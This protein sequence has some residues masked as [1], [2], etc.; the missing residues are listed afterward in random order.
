MV[1]TRKT[2][3]YLVDTIEADI[4]SGNEPPRRAFAADKDC[5]SNPLLLANNRCASSKCTND[6]MTL[7]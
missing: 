1:S 3:V 5:H 4:P 6:P 2:R 7:S